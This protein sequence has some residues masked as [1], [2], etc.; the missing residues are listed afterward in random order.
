MSVSESKF[1]PDRSSVAIGSWAHANMFTSLS[2]DNH[3]ESDPA[4]NKQ[5]TM[6][7]EALGAKTGGVDLIDSIMIPTGRQTT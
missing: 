4:G 2:G 6:S 3:H 7:K 1:S 5:C